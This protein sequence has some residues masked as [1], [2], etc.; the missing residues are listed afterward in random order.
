MERTSVLR[1]VLVFIAISLLGPV[2]GRPV[3]AQ[4]IPAYSSETNIVYCTVAGKSLSL[5]AFLPV[6]TNGPA[7]AIVEIHGGWWYGGRA[8][9][10][11]DG[12]G[13]WQF[14]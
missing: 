13:G 5:N 6:K 1:F 12:V 9:T 2:F 4:E 8:A 7:T 11:L 10:Q 3:M 14:F